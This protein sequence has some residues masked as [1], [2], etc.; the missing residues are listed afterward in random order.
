MN[1]SAHGNTRRW[2]RRYESCCAATTALGLVA[3]ITC[4]S[5]RPTPLIR[6]GV[7]V[8]LDNNRTSLLSQK[9]ATAPKQ[10]LS[11]KPTT[12]TSPSSTS[13]CLA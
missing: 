1:C 13:R 12:S 8:S 9:P 5:I 7:R 10:L 11:Q 6:R 2:M 3:S 4:S